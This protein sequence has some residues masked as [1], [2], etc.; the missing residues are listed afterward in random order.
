MEDEP[1]CGDFFCEEHLVY[2][3][4]VGSEEWGGASGVMVCVSCAERQVCPA[5]GGDGC[6]A[7]GEPCETCDSFGRVAQRE[8]QPV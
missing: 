2:L 3:H 8:G 4:T 5:C 1:Y 6:D 7:E